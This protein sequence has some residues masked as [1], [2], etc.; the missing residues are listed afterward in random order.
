MRRL[1]RYIKKRQEANR[2]PD[3]NDLHDVIRY[4]RAADY[5]LLTSR[6]RHV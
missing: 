3:H 2:K 6:R 1:I 5:D 4:V